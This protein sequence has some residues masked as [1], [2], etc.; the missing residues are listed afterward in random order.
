MDYY[1]STCE[2][3][4]AE[5]VCSTC[6]L[7]TKPAAESAQARRSTP[8]PEPAGGTRRESTAASTSGSSGAG[9]T[10]SRTAPPSEPAAATVGRKLDGEKELESYLKSGYEVFLITGIGGAGKTE[11]LAT[12]RQDGYLRRFIKRGGMVMP[13]RQGA[14]DCHPVSVGDRK[15]LFADASGETFRLLYPQM[16]DTRELTQADIGFLGLI[17][18]GLRGIVLLIELERLWGERQRLEDPANEQQVEIL[19]WILALLRWLTFDGKYVSG[20]IRFQDQVDGSVR[21]MKKRLQIPVQILFSKADQL[22]DFTVPQRLQSAGRLRK[23]QPEERRL[24]PPGEDPFF[25]AYHRLSDLFAAVR[26]HAD[27]F[28]FDFVHSLIT[29]PGSGTVSDSHSCG[30][31]LAIQWLLDPCWQSRWP[32]LPTRRWLQVQRFLDR[33]VGRGQ[34][35]RRLPDPVE[36]KS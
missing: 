4:V 3:L 33:A 26:N 24:Y 29:D 1:C 35:W 12:F 9:G 16:R 21:R 23:G 25:F 11:L 10:A 6:G 31:T 7:P 14:V 2:K 5:E 17:G 13:T 28:R 15:V 8:E 34:R 18:K 32:I 19:S 30:A 20:P 36:V 22:V 27:H